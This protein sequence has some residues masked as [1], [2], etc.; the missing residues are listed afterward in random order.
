MSYWMVVCRPKGETDWRPYEFFVAWR[1][2]RTAACREIAA[3]ERLRESAQR[4]GSR[5]SELEFAPAQ[6]RV[7]PEA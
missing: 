1:Q 2:S 6:V 7:E 5:L 4:M 3:I